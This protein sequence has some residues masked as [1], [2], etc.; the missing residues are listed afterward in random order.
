MD[1]LFATILKDLR[2][3]SRDKVGLLMMF[4]MPILLVI[5]ITSVQNSTFDLVNNNKIAIL[6]S[7]KDTGEASTRFIKAVDKIGMFR[8]QMVNGN[9]S[10]QIPERMHAKDALV[11]L[12]IPKNFS[13]DLITKAQNVATR[14][15][16]DAGVSLD[17]AKPAPVIVEPITLYYHPVL[18][19]S[20]RQSIEGAIHSALQVVQGDEIVKNLYF[21]LHEKQIPASLEDDILHNDIPVTE[22]PV[23]RGGSRNIPNATQHNVPAWTIFAMFFIVISLGSSVVREKLSGSFLRL[24]TLP[25]S[26]MTALLSKQI[27]YLGVTLLQAIIIFSLGIWLFPHIG[28]PKLSLPDDIIGLL[29]ITLICGWCAVSF[30]IC[31]GVF[32]QTQEQ[33]NG[34]GA[35][36][37]II[38]AAIGGLIVPSFA[39]PASFNTIMKISPLHWGLEAYYGL[40]LEGGKLKDIL[41]NILSLLAIIALIQLITLY[42]LKR[43]NLI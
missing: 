34:F 36:S 16:Q 39:M 26:Y 18:Q 38:L 2:I 1:K 10:Q 27:T 31:I 32:A 8:L 42:G 33:S 30:A 28:L 4:A 13:Y 15:L 35:G 40:F 24:K 14:S 43:K 11:A 17:T 7:N 21:S 20:F 37:I 12:V 5:V 25:T 9:D 6:I 3:L 22:I 29:V 19:Q 23:S 41:A